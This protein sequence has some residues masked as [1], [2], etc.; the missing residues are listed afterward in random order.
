MVDLIDFS[1][2]TQ[3]NLDEDKKYKELIL[4]NQI[5]KQ[6]IE[7]LKQKI[8]EIR[9]ISLIEG[10]EKAK[11][12]LLQDLEN[13]KQAY[14][15]QLTKEFEEKLK[16]NLQTYAKNFQDINFKLNEG[17][18]QILDKINAI[19]S[20]SLE[21]I[22]EFISIN[23]HDPKSI[24][25]N[26]SSIVE[27]LKSYKPISIKVG[28]LELKEILKKFIPD[29]EIIHDESM[30]LNDFKVEFEFIKV[31]NNVKEKIQLVKDEI[32]REIKK[33]SEV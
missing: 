5:L 4:E 25:E 18:K 31:E 13:Q 32:K 14:L 10:Y 17:F 3:K 21:E 20:D 28:S 16:Q 11:D 7:E 12:D 30:N 1:K 26:I 23:Y 24:K 2:I 29:I 8:E 22:L 15:N 33:L 19:I 6:N 27:E 9:Q